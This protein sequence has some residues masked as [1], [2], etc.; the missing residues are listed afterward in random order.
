MH[1]KLI[2]ALGSLV[3]ALVLVGLVGELAL[4]AYYFL[5][6][7]ARGNSYIGVRMDDQLGWYPVETYRFK[8]TKTDAAGRSYAADVHF[9]TNGFRTFGDLTTRK[10][11]VLVLGDSVTHA[12]EVSNDKT[13]YALLTNALPIEIFAFGGTGYGNLQEY[14]I[15][16]RFADTI[17]PD[18][19]L[20]QC[21]GND[22]I[23]NDYELERGSYANNNRMRRPYL[24]E[25]GRLFYAL[26]KGG[27]LLR[28][29][30]NRHSRFLYFLFTRLDRFLAGVLPGSEG[31]IA[32][33]G[34]Q[35]PGFRRAVR[36]TGEIFRRAKSRLPNEA[37][38]A[39]FM[40][41]Q[42]SPYYEAMQRIAADNGFCFIPDVGKR[43]EDAE[44]AGVVVRGKDK[45]HWSE[46]GQLIAAETIAEA[47]QR[48]VLE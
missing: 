30:A 45:T 8:G 14:M 12:F 34:E 43:V 31:Q 28:E 19:V 7:T 42:G 29:F 40:A 10:M 4:R 41:D 9:C 23:N 32:A 39:V 21:S 46:A 35:D 1:K 20:W 36:I 17:R 6:F 5:R 22:F 25:Q 24:D 44:R 13:Y 47:V 2:L 48:S 38:V 33:A 3:L 27:I 18:V 26:P 37:R 15:L 11:R 16:D